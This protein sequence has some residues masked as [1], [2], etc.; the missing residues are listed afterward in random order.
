MHSQQLTTQSSNSQALDLPDFHEN[1][2]GVKSLGEPT[3][4]LDVMTPKDQP[5]SGDLT[6]T[7]EIAISQKDQVSMGETSCMSE[8]IEPQNEHCNVENLSKVDESESD[9]SEDSYASLDESHDAHQDSSHDIIACTAEIEALKD[10]L[11]KSR[12]EVLSL[13]SR[14]EEG[15]SMKA[16]ELDESVDSYE[17]KL[18]EFRQV[19]MTLQDRVFQSET[20]EKQL[21]EKLKLAEYTINDL[22]SSENSARENLEICRKSEMN[23]KKSLSSCQQKIRE[24]KEIILDKDV[25]E[26]NLAEKVL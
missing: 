20:S 13:R 7:N 2:L 15:M 10:D 5:S 6:R 19:C 22:E 1:Q 14:L 17:S 26:M 9:I 8:N 21:R 18:E 23:C 16:D 25:S 24:L 11:N 12:E 3:Q 4:N